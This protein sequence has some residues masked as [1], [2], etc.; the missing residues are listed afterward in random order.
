M[1]RCRATRLRTRGVASVV[2]DGR[3]GLTEGGVKVG[4]G[5]GG[6]GVAGVFGT[7][8]RGGERHVEVLSSVQ[9]LCYDSGRVMLGII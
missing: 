3:R 6:G 5:F 7:G 1:L 4:I 2:D 9:Y 8:D